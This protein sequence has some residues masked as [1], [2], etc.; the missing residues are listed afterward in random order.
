M[1][2]TS[3]DDY[4]WLVYKQPRSIQ[5]VI[6]AEPDACRQYLL[7]KRVQSYGAFWQ[8]VTG[9]LED[10]ESHS[11]AAVREVK[12]E[13]GICAAERDLIDLHLTNVFK[14]APQWLRKYLPGTTYNEEVCFALNVEQ[15]E[16]NLD[17]REHDAFLWTGYEQAMEMLYWDSNK[18]ALAAVHQLESY[19][20]PV[21]S[22][23]PGKAEP[24]VREYKNK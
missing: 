10:G 15:T 19:P 1:L 7:L 21:S 24:H 18:R 3:S 20:S 5:V 22:L 12:E 8:S 4:I 16:I 14:I 6:F 23:E 11:Q 2:V 17:L 13:T 9:S